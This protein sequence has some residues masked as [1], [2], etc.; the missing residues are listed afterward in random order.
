M[1]QRLKGIR[2]DDKNKK[3]VF[4]PTVLSPGVCG[5]AI[6][7]QSGPTEERGGRERAPRSQHQDRQTDGKGCASMFAFNVLINLDLLD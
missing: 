2:E 5:A 7:A 1:T 6:S 3:T 4:N